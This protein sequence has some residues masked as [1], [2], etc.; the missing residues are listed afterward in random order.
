MLQLFGQLAASLDVSPLTK[1]CQ[2]AV[3]AHRLCFPG[4]YPHSNNLQCR[5]QALYHG[6]VPRSSTGAQTA[7]QSSSPEACAA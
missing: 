2:A 4:E 5:V 1:I 3:L 7:V 6:G